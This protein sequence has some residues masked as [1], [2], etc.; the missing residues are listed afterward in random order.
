MR[1]R[2]VRRIT[3]YPISD[4][5]EYGLIEQESLDGA[6][7]LRDERREVLERW[8]GQEGV[9]AQFGHWR[10]HEWS[11]AKADTAKSTGIEEG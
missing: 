2:W 6:S 1:K 3:S 7:D 11:E 5:C 4:A 8:H 9:E 10:F